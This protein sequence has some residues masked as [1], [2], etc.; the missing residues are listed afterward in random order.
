[1]TSFDKKLGSLLV[2]EGKIPTDD[3]R[4]L[5]VQAAQEKRPLSGLA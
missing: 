3:L 5:L 2:K 1:M 4:E